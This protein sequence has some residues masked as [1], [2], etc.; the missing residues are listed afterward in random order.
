MSIK[1]CSSNVVFM[2]QEYTYSNKVFN[3]IHVIKINGEVVYREVDGEVIIDRRNPAIDETAIELDSL[4]FDEIKKD[5]KL[6]STAKKLYKNRK[7][8]KIIIVFCSLVLIYSIYKSMPVYWFAGKAVT[9]NTTLAV[10]GTTM[11]EGAPSPAEITTWKEIE[12]VQVFLDL[13]I[14]IIRVLAVSIC[15]LIAAN[16]GLKIAMDENIDGQKEAKKAAG[17]ILWAL[18]LV[19]VG[20]SIA[21]LIGTKLL[22]GI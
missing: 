6:M 8:R 4:Q 9:V 13:I 19:F 3:K 22:G 5:N 14:N 17:K 21:G 2:K 1:G 10:A 11:L 12:E 7:L 18:F 15:G 20:T 16:T